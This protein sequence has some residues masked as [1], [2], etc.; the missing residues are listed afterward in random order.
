M[1][2]ANDLI[3]QLTARAAEVDDWDFSVDHQ[4]D[5]DGD[6]YITL[7][8]KYEEKPEGFDPSEPWEVFAMDHLIDA[9]KFEASPGNDH[10]GH[11][12]D[13][14]SFSVVDGSVE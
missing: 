9:H 6:G 3:A 14:I 5:E 8:V 4:I 13:C 2:T 1:T 12:H 7:S 10:Q 11:I